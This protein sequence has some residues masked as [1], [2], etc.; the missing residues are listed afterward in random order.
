MRNELQG[1]TGKKRAEKKGKVER[2]T[3]NAGKKA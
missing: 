1:K 2:K 3:G